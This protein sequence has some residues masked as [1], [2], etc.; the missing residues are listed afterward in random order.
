ML[1]NREALIA[2]LGRGGEKG[3]AREM[4]AVPGEAATFIAML[5]VMGEHEDP[6]DA[7]RSRR[8]R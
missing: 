3:L 8:L 5:S 1:S 6:R 7:A 4:I 2:L